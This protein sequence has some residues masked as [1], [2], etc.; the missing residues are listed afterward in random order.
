MLAKMISILAKL[1]KYSDIQLT[2]VSLEDQVKPLGFL[3]P[4]LHI[5]EEFPNLV[6]T[7]DQL[8]NEDP[9]ASLPMVDPSSEEISAKTSLNSDPTGSWGVQ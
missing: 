4:S 7:S 9:V 8:R 2:Q 3:T 1:I 5:V 6:E